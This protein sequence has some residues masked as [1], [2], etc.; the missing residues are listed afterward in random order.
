MIAYKKTQVLSGNK[1]IYYKNVKGEN[2]E[3]DR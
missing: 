2:K 1:G 3:N